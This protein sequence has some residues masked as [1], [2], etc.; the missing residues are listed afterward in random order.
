[1]VGGPDAGV[2]HGGPGP[3]T[4]VDEVHTDP[5]NEVDIEG[6]PPSGCDRDWDSFLSV[7][8][9]RIIGVGRCVCLTLNRKESETVG[10]LE[11]RRRTSGGL[12]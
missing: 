10:Q 9:G 3:D 6:T 12:H 11:T 4:L 2:G 8:K 1:M 5:E 7:R